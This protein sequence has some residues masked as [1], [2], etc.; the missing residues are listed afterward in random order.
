VE[1]AL[2]ELAWSYGWSTQTCEVAAR[3][4]KLRLQ[5]L[6][7]RMRWEEFCKESFDNPV[8]LEARK[9]FLRTVKQVVEDIRDCHNLE[10]PTGS[11]GIAAAFDTLSATEREVVW[12][13][14]VAGNSWSQIAEI[15]TTSVSYVQYLYKTSIAELLRHLRDFDWGEDPSGGGPGGHCG[16]RPSV[17]ASEDSDHDSAC[18]KQG[19]GPPSP[20]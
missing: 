16:A 12:R 17:P 5:A 19:G 14:V 3:E 10:T 20:I 6:C 2:G 1:K 9:M 15:L 13:R 8:Y 7:G 4:V 11:V 18:E